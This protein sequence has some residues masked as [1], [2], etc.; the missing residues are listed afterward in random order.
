MTI[1][2]RHKIT[3]VRISEV[4]TEGNYRNDNLEEVGAGLETDNIQI[5]SEEMTEVVVGQDQVQEPV[6]IETELDV[7]SVRNMIILLR[8]V[9]LYR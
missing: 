4:D 5:I 8:I 6:I 1:L 2:E 7:V 3:E 9:Q